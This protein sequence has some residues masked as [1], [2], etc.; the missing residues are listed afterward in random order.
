MKKFIALV[1]SISILGLFF[2]LT[3][4]SQTSKFTNQGNL[5]VGSV[6]E[7][8]YD[9]EFSLFDSALGGVQIGKT[10]TQSNV[11]VKNGEYLVELDFGNISK[12]NR[13][14]EIKYKKSTETRYKTKATRQQI[15][16]SN[17]IVKMGTI[18]ANVFLACGPG[19]GSYNTFCGNSA[20]G[21]IAPTANRNSFFG[22][23]AGYFNTSGYSN[24]F[25]GYT[26]GQSNSTGRYNSFFGRAAGLRNTTGTHNT[27]VGYAADVGS[28][29]LTYATAI[30]SGARVTTSRT[31]QLGRNGLDKV[32]IGTLGSGGS[33]TLCQNK[34]KEIATCSSSIR[35]KSNVKDYRLGLNL[36]RKLRPVSFKWKDSGTLDVGLVA[37]E[38]EGVEPLLTTTNSKGEI[39]GVKYGRVGVV[40]VNAVKEQQLQIEAQKE[41]IKRQQEQIEKQRK[42]LEAIKRLVCL[43]NANAEICKSEN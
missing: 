21:K 17:I 19:A 41:T 12:A 36:I 14:V 34:N 28:A 35:Y 25:F 43:Q 38:V 13:F 5:P 6:A 33:T 7:D 4:F 29:G 32:R 18:R 1:F 15:A 31:I 9:F 37:E 3:I 39:E 26:A 10:I 42:K 23:S 20:G 2:N 40:L 11:P 16:D 22:H 8:S 27:N 24:S 30:G